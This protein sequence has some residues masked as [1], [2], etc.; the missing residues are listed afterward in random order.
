MANIFTKPIKVIREG[1]YV[2]IITW[3]ELKASTE[4]LSHFNAYI[5][6][7]D[8]GL[9][10]HGGITYKN[11]GCVGWDYAHHGDKCIYRGEET[12]V[13]GGAYTNNATIHT[14]DT[15]TDDIIEAINTLQSHTNP[16][17]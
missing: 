1:D 2:G 7:D 14:I 15:V 3:R 6:T 13:M 10:V 17:P 16:F 5:I 12:D 11:G 4:N 9:C 8:T